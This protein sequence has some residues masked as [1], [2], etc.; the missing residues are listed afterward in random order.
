MFSKMLVS[1]NGSENSFIALEH[2]IF[3]KVTRNTNYIP[4][5]TLGVA[6][7]LYLFTK[8]LWKNSVQI[9]KANL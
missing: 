2:A 3:F 4:L 5:Y 7:S 8:K 6:Y 9:I 1:I